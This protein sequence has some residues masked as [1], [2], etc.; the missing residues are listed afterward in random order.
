MDIWVISEAQKHTQLPELPYTKS[1]I[2]ANNSKKNSDEDVSIQQ[3][4]LM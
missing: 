4:L 2:D 1:K 3:Y